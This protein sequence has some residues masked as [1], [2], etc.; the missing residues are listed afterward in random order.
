VSRAGSPI[1]AVLEPVMQAGIKVIRLNR[2]KKPQDTEWQLN[3]LEPEAIYKHAARGGNVGAQVGEVSGWVCAV[4]PDCEEAERLAPAFLPKTLTIA[5]GDHLPSLYVYR[6]PGLGFVCFND[7][8]ADV[9]NDQKRI[10]DVKAS[11]NGKGHQFLIPP[12]VHPDKGPY[13]W[14][15]GF[16]AE[17][18][19]KIDQEEL[20][21]AIGHLVAATLITRRLPATGRHDFAMALAGYTLRNGEA[22]DD[23]L[24]ILAEAWVFH[25]APHEAFRDLEGIVRDTRDALRGS[26]PV[27]GGPTLDELSPGLPRALAKAFGWESPDNYESPT[28]GSQPSTSRP[29]RRNLTDLGNAERLVDQHGADIRYCHPWRKWFSWDGRRGVVDTSGDVRRRARQTVRLI[30]AE[31]SA[32]NSDD[33]R[34]AIA[35]WAMG[36]ESKG[37]IDAMVS[38]AEAEEGIPVTPNVLD[39]DPWKLNVLNGTIDLKA[40]ELLEHNRRDHITKMAPTEYHKDAESPNWHSTLERVL[41]SKELRRFFQKLVGCALIG[42]VSEHILAILYGTGANGKSTILNALLDALGDYGMQAATDLLV[43]KPRSHP[44]ELADL[45]GMRFVASIE[46]EEGSRLAE[47]LVKQLTGG[48]R[49]KARRMRE[50]FWEFEPSH[51]VFM[52]AN[53]KPQI[54]GT[55]VGIWRRIRLIPFTESIPIDQQDKQL[56]T[57]LRSELSGILAWAVEGCLAWQSDGLDAPDEVRR[58]TGTYRAEMDVLAAFLEDRCVVREGL[59]A[60]ATPL[61]KQYQLW[62]SDTGEDPGTQKMFGMRLSERGFVSKRITHGAHKG[63]KGWRGI[64]LKVDHPRPDDPA[65][66]TITTKNGAKTSDN[67]LRSEPSV[68]DRSPAESRIDQPNTRKGVGGVNDGEPNSDINSSKSSPRAVIQKKVHHRS[69]F[70]DVPV[71][72]DLEP[73]ETATVEDL[74]QR[75]TQ[76]DSEEEDVQRSYDDLVDEA[77]ERLED[78]V[79]FDALAAQLDEESE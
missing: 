33:E 76:C 42:D 29:I 35:K 54:R 66:P 70:T 44:T 15:G 51:T 16:D 1:E 49:I 78:D 60:P 45:F 25:N 9:P 43:A 46:V 58:A 27:T 13:W 71:S 7:P 31:A 52:S 21:K 22:T 79:N 61:F 53:H 24:K 48:D 67:G 6:S 59:V 3:T 65:P 56:P 30:Y 17:K 10:L 26:R 57:K 5:K 74:K 73:G 40:G 14:V 23:V 62:C 2:E 32:A 41:P 75:R 28:P 38:I 47:S 69:P 20:R 11:N 34:K 39:S 50:D 68:D 55:D 4:D 36:S 77:T 18:I 8:G 12:A 72:F 37:R 19:L 64:G 63:Q